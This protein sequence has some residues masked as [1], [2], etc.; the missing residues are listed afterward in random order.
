MKNRNLT[1]VFTVT[2]LIVIACMFVNIVGYSGQQNIKSQNVH[3]I[4]A[5]DG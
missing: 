4:S 5:F 1:A 2:G 3:V